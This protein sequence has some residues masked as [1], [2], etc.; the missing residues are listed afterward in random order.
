MSP[1][2]IAVIGGISVGDH[3]GGFAVGLLGGW[4]IGRYLLPLPKDGSSTA[5]VAESD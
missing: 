1:A 3:L 5:P 2:E 4:I